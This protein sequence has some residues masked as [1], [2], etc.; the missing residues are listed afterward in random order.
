MKLL[1]P[2]H[3]AH[4]EEGVGQVQVKHHKVSYSFECGFLLIA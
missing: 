2:G 3:D 1:P 4:A